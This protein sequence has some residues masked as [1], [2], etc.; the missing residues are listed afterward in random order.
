MTRKTFLATTFYGLRQLH[1]FQESVPREEIAQIVRGNSGPFVEKPYL[2]IGRSRSVGSD[3]EIEVL[4]HARDEPQPW[5]VLYKGK[6][7]TE[8]RKSAAPDSQPVR[9]WSDDHDQLRLESWSTGKDEYGNPARIN[10]YST[11]PLPT[12]EPH[13]VWK[14]RLTGL[15]AGARFDY[16]VLLDGKPVFAADGRTRPARGQR[17]RIALVADFGDPL[18]APRAIAH[19]ILVEQPD[20]VVMPGDMVYLHGR[21]SEYRRGYFPNYNSDVASPSTGA[22]LLRSI[23]TI[24]G[25]GE[26]DTGTNSG[27]PAPHDILGYYLYWSQPLNGLPLRIGDPCVFPISPTD[28][29][30]KALLESAGSNFPIMAHFSA[31]VGDIHFTFVDTARHVDW[32]NPALREWLRQDLA[33]AG[34]DMWKVMICYLPLFH[35]GK[36]YQRQKMR[37]IA[38]IVQEQGVSLMIGGMHH[39]YQ[40][41]R[42]LLYRAYSQTLGV[43]K[44][45][46][47]VLPGEFSIDTNYDGLRNQ[48]PRGVIHIVTGTGG[49]EMHN[50]DQ[51]R[52][53]A[54]W[55]PYTHR[56]ASDRYSFTLLDATQDKLEARQLDE[57]GNELD[58]YAIRRI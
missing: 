1:A 6:A 11:V 38:D 2:Q 10:S 30:Q 56:Y 41:T 36:D 48:T 55:Q 54:T 13:R 19:R 46:D 51:T 58:S 44:D 50:Q 29:R 4:W 53:P 57:E 24:A 22:P 39:S 40:R 28:A 32:K 8:W 35:S 52:R 27:N 3:T 12:I 31:D 17:A 49:H 23:P 26:H 5:S 42:P 43:V 37:I 21:V 25:L 7:E 47:M 34:R 20:V 18:P 33:H 14:A 15:K 9:L 16:Q 45:Y